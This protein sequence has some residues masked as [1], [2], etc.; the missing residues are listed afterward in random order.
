MLESI[1][2]VKRWAHE[3]NLIEGSDSI[4]QY[5]KLVSELGELADDINKKQDVRDSVG[6]CLVVLII[7]G[8][9]NYVSNSRYIRC[10]ADIVNGD[11]A[12]RGEQS[13]KVYGMWLADAVGRI[14][15]QLSRDRCIDD[16]IVDCVSHLSAIADLSGGYTLAHCLEHAYNEIKDRKGVMLDGVFI[17]EDDSAYAAAVEL[18]GKD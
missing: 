3:R 10:F 13:P 14:G 9:Q 16:Q 15:K 1:G 4:T 18:L 11:V 8:E 2:K 12:Y 17:K 7:L 5:L 6:D